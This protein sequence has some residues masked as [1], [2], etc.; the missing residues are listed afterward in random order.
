M[1]HLYKCCQCNCLFHEDDIKYV[2]E[3]R[4]EFWGVPCTETM[5][6]SPCCEA[7][8]EEYEEESDLWVCKD[9]GKIWTSDDIDE[10]AVNI[11][12]YEWQINR[13]CPDCLG[14]LQPYIEED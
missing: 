5:S 1:L 3:P 6:Y 13:S 4:G 2:E 7:D 14:E 11:G 10:E 9:C 12:G 8:Y